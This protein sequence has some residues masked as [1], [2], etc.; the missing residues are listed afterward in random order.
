MAILDILVYPNPELKKISA[1]VAEID[2]PMQQLIADLTETLYASPGCV[3]IAA[4]QVGA[5]V[6][7][8][9][10]DTS[11]NPR[12]ASQHG[13]LILINPKIVWQEGE[14]MG[15]EGCL[16]L[17]DFTA[18]V[19]RAKSIRVEAIDPQGNALSIEASDFEARVILHEADHLDGILFLD[20]VTS[21]K[22]DVFRRK[23]YAT[24]E[25]SE[26]KGTAD[27]KAGSESKES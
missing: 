16:S 26:A 20:R 9:I 7:L 3:G 27:A 19:K 18:N 14:V 24:K 12:F 17:P 1:A 21:L 5:L 11:R 22:T 4:P 6:R 15:R 25:L 2:A 8:V 13:Q 23:R 10:V